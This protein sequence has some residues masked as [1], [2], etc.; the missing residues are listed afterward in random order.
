MKNASADQILVRIAPT[1]K[2]KCGRG[3][4]HT[5]RM[6]LASLVYLSA[7]GKKHSFFAPHSHEVLV[8]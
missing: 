1:I 2:E 3:E 7:G 6:Y 5:H 4:T 8:K